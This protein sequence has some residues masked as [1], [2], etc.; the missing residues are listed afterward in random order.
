MLGTNLKIEWKAQRGAC[1]ED[2]AK[3]EVKNANV[4]AYTERI[5]QICF[6]AGSEGLLNPDQ[7]VPA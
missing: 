7:P 6:E 3:F 1:G 4:S 5:L 2:S